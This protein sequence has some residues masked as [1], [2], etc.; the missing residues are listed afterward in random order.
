MSSLIG[1]VPEFRPHG[2]NE[3]WVQYIERLEFYF[4]ANKTVINPEDDFQK[5]TILLSGVG[6]KTYNLIRNLVAPNKPS[7]KTF[8]EI[9]DLV[10]KHHSR[11]PSVIVERYRFNTR[12]RKQVKISQTMWQILE[13]LQN[14]ANLMQTPWMKC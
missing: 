12:V 10:Q 7:D 5:K 2:E 1:N 11:T 6:A 8:K 3:E 14:I 4:Q 13:N 9:V